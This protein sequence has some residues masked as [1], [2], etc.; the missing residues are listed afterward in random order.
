MQPL[1]IA[2]PYDASTRIR[3]DGFDEGEVPR[4]GI[5]RVVDSVEAALREAG[6]DAV[7]VPCDYPVT[8][9]V[10]A[11]QDGGFDSDEHAVGGGA[12]QAAMLTLTGHS[13]RAVMRSSPRVTALTLM[14]TARS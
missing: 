9:F 5:H 7:R 3:P 4:A 6:H 11:L 8:G 14:K 1:R 10:S 2:I 12:V 13:P